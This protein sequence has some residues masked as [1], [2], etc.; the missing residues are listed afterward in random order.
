VTRHP[1]PWTPTVATREYYQR[2]PLGTIIAVNRLPWRVTDHVELDPLD[3]TEDEHAH[4]RHVAHKLSPDQ[5]PDRPWTL[6]LD[7]LPDGGTY[8]TRIPAFR[9]FVWYVLPEHYAVCVLCQELHPCRHVTTEE[10]VTRAGEHLDR[11]T[12][13]GPEACWACGDPITKRQHSI[14][15]WGPNLLLPGGPT[16][17][18]F[19]TRR[20][21]VSCLQAA[22]E[23][24]QVWVAED[25][26]R[27]IRLDVNAGI[28]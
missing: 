5:W 19:H 27:P 26:S 4:Y 23:Y 1:A 10:E 11:L 17:V 24:E 6:I 9:P 28:G 15:F 20:N 13:V 21:P 22:C 7:A 18:R 16:P 3:W 14:A 8:E 2:P 12:S 25:P